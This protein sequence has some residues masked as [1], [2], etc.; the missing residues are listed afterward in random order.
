M[1]AYL[2]AADVAEAVGVST[3]TVLRWI[4][5][6]DLEAVRL[7]GGRLRVSQA[8]L[9]AHLAAWSTLIGRTDGCILP[10]VPPFEEE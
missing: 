7:P 4:D 3:R 9:A 8:A 10:P 6:G 2:T 1:T 5:R